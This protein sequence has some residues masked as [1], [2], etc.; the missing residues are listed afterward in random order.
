MDS[1]TPQVQPVILAIDGD[2][3]GVLGIIQA[4]RRRYSADYE[5]RSAASGQAAL[6]LLRDMRDNGRAVV[7]LLC[8]QSLPDMSGIE[9]F[10]RAN[11]LH[12]RAKRA[13]LIDWSDRF[14]AEPIFHTFAL[15]QIDGYTTRPAAL[16]DQPDERFHEFVT[17]LLREWSRVNRP[18]FQVVQIIGE[19][20]APRSHELRDLFARNGIPYGFYDVHSE[21]GQ[22]LLQN[23]GALDGPLP[24]LIFLDNRVMVNPA[25]EAIADAFGVNTRLENF[26]YDVI[27]VG[28][29]PAGLSAAVY[30]ASEGLHTIVIESRAIGG[31]AG[32]SSLIRNYL[33]FPR[34]ISGAAL[35]ARAYEQAWFFGAHFYFM[36][37]AAALRSTG[38]HYVVVLDDG[39]EL[40]GRTVIL[41]MGAAYRHLD[42]PHLNT[43]VGSGVFYGAAVT[44]AKAMQG[45]EVFVVGG[46]NA[47]GQ[48]AVY[49]S[50][51]ASRVTML[52]RGDSLTDTM[53][54]YLM[55]DIVTC[56]NIEVCCNVEIAAC[57]GEHRLEGLR[58]RDMA[59]GEETA[60]SGSALFILIG[61]SPH[62]QW[63]P[64]TIL[65]DENGYVITG[66]DL[67]GD[68]RYSA[69]WP[70]TRMPR[71][72]ETSLPGVFAV[73]DLRHRSVKR[74]ASAVGEGSVTISQV[75]EYLQELKTTGA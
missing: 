44:E 57:Y 48:A 17:D 54:D 61:A 20:W 14:T 10:V 47:A 69:N 13:L 42:L 71:P 5:I 15:G 29:G 40:L 67:L 46:G 2:A 30:G 16:D 64:E 11:P 18:A 45:K 9:F 68:G 60:V 66:Q 33:G 38:Q 73:G 12:P 22:T 49:L 25:N 32:T 56:G 59:T 65:C 27:I 70:L 52:V 37:Q 72:F 6:Q 28:A 1:P 31:Q 3:V 63:L 41:A 23:A 51:F 43:L 74:V 26:A 19:E 7:L 53:S 36:R 8:A 55:N 62:T 4:L 21:D 35:A 39:T 50:K 24:V 34:G 75:H 58:V